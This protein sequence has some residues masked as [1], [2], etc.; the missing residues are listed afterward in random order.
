MIAAMGC[1][2]HPPTPV[3][4][5]HAPSWRQHCAPL[6]ERSV[7][8]DARGIEHLA[9]P[10]DDNLR[11]CWQLAIRIVDAGRPVA[12]PPSCR[13]LRVAEPRPSADWLARCRRFEAGAS[14]GRPVVAKHVQP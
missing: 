5:N 1:G 14:L 6:L 2:G 13:A 7:H 10:V 3:V 9:A 8:A 11:M 12:P 4:S